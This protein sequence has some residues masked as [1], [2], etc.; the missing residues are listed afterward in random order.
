MNKIL[1][2]WH[3]KALHTLSAVESGDRPAAG[4]GAQ[5]PRRQEAP[6]AV[7]EDLA[8]MDRY[9]RRMREERGKEE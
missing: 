2:S 9:L 8:R 1:T 4:Q 3:Q 5:S 7:R 6:G